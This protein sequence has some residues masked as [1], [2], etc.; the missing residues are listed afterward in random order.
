MPDLDGP[1]TLAARR[2][3]ESQRGIAAQM[4]VKI[5]MTTVN[6]D[7]VSI[8]AALKN[9]R[10]GYLVKPITRESLMNNL[11]KFALVP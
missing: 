1:K 10:E 5:I 4:G 7:R 11:E 9:Q 6:V 8:D 3:V 2:A